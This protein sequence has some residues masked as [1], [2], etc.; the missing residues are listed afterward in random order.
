M[1][2]GGAIINNARKLT[3]LEKAIKRVGDEARRRLKENDLA[4]K[5]SLS[6]E[7]DDLRD[8]R[9]D[10]DSSPDQRDAEL[11]AQDRLDDDG[12]MYERG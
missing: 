11:D 5:G 8:W 4:Y 6:E 7:I 12:K 2:E 1:H 9:A 3:L 10:L